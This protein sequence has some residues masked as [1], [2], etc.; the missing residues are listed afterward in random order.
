[1]R[2][3]K[4][5]DARLALGSAL[6]LLLAQ[7]LATSL[8]VGR[9][10]DALLGQ[11]EAQTRRDFELAAAQIARL[12][13]SARRGAGMLL[14]REEVET[15]LN[16]RFSRGPERMRAL[17][18]ALDAI[19]ETLAYDDS[20][21]GVWF[22]REDG[23]TLGA[24][25]SWHFAGEETPHPLFEAVKL[26]DL[27]QSGAVLWLGAW[28]LGDLTRY[29]P[30]GAQADASEALILGALRTDYRLSGDEAARSVLTVFA[31]GQEEMRRCLESLYS[32]GEE[33]YLL[34][35]E[36]RQ[37]AGTRAEAL[38][39]APWFLP[40]FSEKESGVT[41]SRGDDRYR[42]V[43]HELPGLG[44]T[45]VKAIPFDLYAGQA[46]RLRAA[47]WGAGALVLLLA[48]AAYSVWAVRTLRPLREM[49]AALNRVRA[50]DL[51]V[52]LERPYDVEEFE[53]MRSSFNSM[54]ASIRGML[55][56]TRAMEHERIELELRNL[57]SQLNPHMVFNSITSIRFM[58]MMSGADKVSD[59][60]VCL[61][62]LIRPVFSEWR[63]LWPLG[64]ELDYA[65]NYVKL[66]TLRF[67]G[68]VLVRFDVEPG[69]ERA[70]LPCF[71][72]QP[73][74][75]NSVQHGMVAGRPLNVRVA[76][77][78]DG[79]GTL[80]LTVE[81]DGAGIPPDKLEAL[82]RRMDEPQGAA[83]ADAALGHTGIGVLNVCRRARMLRDGER[84]GELRIESAPGRGTRIELRLP[85][86]PGEA[87]E[88]RAEADAIARLGRQ[89]GDGRENRDN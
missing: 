13:H 65:R 66:L 67:G 37:L 27:P 46:R 87:E 50:G 47:A 89:S 18:A 68:Q 48:V 70:Q 85:F 17:L 55:Q 10:Q 80:L 45:L 61:A 42:L 1:M 60:L 75:E 29:P 76:A 77:G 81:D 22:F 64:D 30:R 3:L 74:L 25:A 82:R 21:S 51:N 71:T 14:S 8:L 20:L 12:T 7:I 19:D 83:E 72:L 36:G 4:R 34:D 56:K 62:D 16:G 28:K 78:T 49:S 57:Q 39:E 86:S 79:E 6:F 26:R 24:T 54:L 69:T 88:T 11:N 15:Y 5:F 44:W 35:G 52:T 41:A 58:A 2:L 40:L 63:L 32:E 9:Y 53:T 33:V 43:R 23:A 84:A 59:M 31:I 38:G 73:L